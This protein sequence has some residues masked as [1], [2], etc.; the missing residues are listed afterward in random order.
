MEF[1]RSE[2]LQRHVEAAH[3]IDEMEGS[4][5]DEKDITIDTEQKSHD[6]DY[7]PEPEPEACYS[8]FVCLQECPLPMNRSKMHAQLP[9]TDE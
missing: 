8:S 9:R 1:V 2:D 7:E 5:S 4:T 3:T 6:E